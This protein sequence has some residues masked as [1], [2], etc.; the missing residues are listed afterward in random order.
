MQDKAHELSSFANNA[1]FT[2]LNEL[3]RAAYLMKVLY[4]L[5]VLGEHDASSLSDHKVG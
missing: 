1:Y 2:L 4:K 3:M 5:D